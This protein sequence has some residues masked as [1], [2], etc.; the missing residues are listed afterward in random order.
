MIEATSAQVKINTL[1][2]ELNEKLTAALSAER[3]RIWTAYK[4]KEKIEE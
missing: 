3:M 4:E 1:R 2:T